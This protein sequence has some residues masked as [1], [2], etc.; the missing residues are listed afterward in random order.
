MLC[1]ERQRGVLALTRV[2]LGAARQVP[3]PVFELVNGQALEGVLG[4]GGPGQALVEAESHVGYSEVE[5]AQQQVEHQ[6]GC[7]DC[8]RGVLYNRAR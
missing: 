6:V 1:S 7:C 8:M 2:G 5:A 3:L 4:E